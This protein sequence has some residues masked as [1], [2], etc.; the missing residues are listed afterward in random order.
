MT[1]ASAKDAALTQAEKDADAKAQGAAADLANVKTDLHNAQQAVKDPNNPTQAEKLAIA[2]A[3]QRVK[4]YEAKDATAKA[5]LDTAKKANQAN[6]AAYA[7]AE[8]DQKAA[9]AA[10]SA[11]DIPALQAAKTA[12]DTAK[13]TA[14]AAVTA[15]ETA[16]KPF[17][18][19]VDTAQKALDAHVK[20]NP[21]TDVAKKLSQDAAALADAKKAAQDQINKVTDP[22]KKAELQKELDAAKDLNAANAAKANADKAVAAQGGNNNNSGSN[23][24]NVS[25]G[26]KNVN[27]ANHKKGWAKDNNGR[28]I[29]Y[30]GVGNELYNKPGWQK[31]TS[32]GYTGWLYE[33]AD[34]SYAT[35]EWKKI[36]GTWYHFRATGYLDTGWH[37]LGKRWFY[38][39]KSGKL[40][41]TTKWEKSHGKW[42]KGLGDKGYAT[43]E[44]VG[45]YSFDGNGY[46]K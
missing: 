27:Q 46:L 14:D 8:K 41:T 10:N 6:K 4:D 19:A 24:G 40:Y 9:V 29:W 35:N 38:F 23:N 11:L 36:G 32:K 26:D 18:A 28:W 16:H 44:K 15:A 7:A 34:K 13:T 33:N 30:T 42:M 37:K 17:A 21:D 2:N 39:S 5:E 25:S 45:K 3:E 12:A 20:A 22:A 43:S 31:Y 1:D